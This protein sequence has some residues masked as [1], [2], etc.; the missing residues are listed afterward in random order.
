MA[1]ALIVRKEGIDM[2]LKSLYMSLNKLSRD[3]EWTPQLNLYLAEDEFV[4]A[5]KHQ[6]EAWK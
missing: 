6:L 1:T 2:F 5:I 3:E 4:I